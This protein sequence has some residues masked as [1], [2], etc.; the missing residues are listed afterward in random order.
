MN[1][2]QRILPL[3]PLPLVQFPGA[4]TPLH[5]FEPRYRQLLRDV[6]SSDKTFGIIYRSETEAAMPAGGSVGCTVEVVASQELPDGRSNILCIGV[7]RFRTLEDVPGEPY[8][9]AEVEMIDDQE[10]GR[11]LTSQVT[12]ASDL[13]QR[14]VAASQKLKDLIGEDEDEVPELPSEAPALSFIIASHLE[15]E[16]VEKQE[17]LELTNTGERLDRLIE[18]LTHLAAD[19]EQR[20]LLHQLSKT[21][22]HGGPLPD[23]L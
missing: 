16:A 12:R 22:G 19:Y 4:I 6:L 21:N 18:W 13:F 17:L 10:S 2:N 7:R 20:A 5:I 14:V 11:D 3:F 8:L 15:L 9:Q 23:P 1:P